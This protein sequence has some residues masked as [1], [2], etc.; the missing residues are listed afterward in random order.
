MTMQATI[1]DG[2]LLLMRLRQWKESNV[3][4]EEAAT[5]TGRSQTADCDNGWGEM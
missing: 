4:I 1:L 2:E 5:E 3:G